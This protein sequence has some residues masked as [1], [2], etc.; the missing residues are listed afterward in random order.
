MQEAEHRRAEAST[1]DRSG[2]HHR[3]VGNLIRGEFE[4]G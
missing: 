1:A 3:I 4:R 2:V